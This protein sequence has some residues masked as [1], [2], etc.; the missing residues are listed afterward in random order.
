M[1]IKT[2]TS[3]AKLVGM[4]TVCVFLFSQASAQQADANKY[5]AGKGAQ[6]GNE[7]MLMQSSGTKAVKSA[8][9]AATIMDNGDV[10]IQT[11]NEKGDAVTETISKPTIDLKSRIE[12]NHDAYVNG[13]IQWVKSNPNYADFVSPQELSLIQAGDFEHLYKNNYYMAQKL[14]SANK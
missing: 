4:L 13:Y 6:R 9:G 5:P 1:K 11:T 2:L 3:F 8:N 10:L 12:T 14:S 7:P